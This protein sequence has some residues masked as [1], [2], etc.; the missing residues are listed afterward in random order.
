MPHPAVCVLCLPL[1]NFT[2]FTF[3]P[4]DF[5]VFTF[6]G[7]QLREGRSGGYLR[8]WSSTLHPYLVVLLLLLLLCS[9]F[10]HV[11]PRA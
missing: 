8:L 3:F 2:I 10:L 9:R 4:P 11:Y 6:A 5:S 7:T 1:Q